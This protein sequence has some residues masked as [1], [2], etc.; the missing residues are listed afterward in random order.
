MSLLCLV[1]WKPILAST[2]WKIAVGCLLQDEKQ[3]SLYTSNLL[4]VYEAENHLETIWDY[5]MEK[6]NI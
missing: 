3:N 6:M 2:R 1:W 5:N 4:C